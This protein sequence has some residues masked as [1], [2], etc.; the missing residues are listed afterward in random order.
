M[1]ELAPDECKELIAEYIDKAS[2]NWAHMAIAQLVKEGYVKRILTTNFD[3]L[4]VKACAT[5][6]VFPAVYDLAASPHFN[7]A[8]AVQTT[9]RAVR[10]RCI[11]RQVT[12]IPSVP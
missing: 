6:G 3:P 4:V 2:I 7:A 1:A 10:L 12:R 9:R 5:V 8:A 11:V